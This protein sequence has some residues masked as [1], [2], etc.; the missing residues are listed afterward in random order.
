MSGEQPPP[1]GGGE[2]E[3]PPPG[4]SGS[5]APTPGW[6]Q[7]TPP[8]PPPGAPSSGGAETPRWL[9]PGPSPA[10]SYQAAYPTPPAY[11]LQQSPTGVPPGAAHRPGAIPLR[12]LVLGDIL[13]GAFRIIRGLLR[14]L[15]V[16]VIDV[17]ADDLPPALAD[18]YLSLKARGLL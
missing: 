18:H 13:D 16:D 11:A 7:V 4:W 3:P 9:Q 12:P 10:P 15:G 6:G 14:T 1:P 8:P 17:P 2:P 5:P